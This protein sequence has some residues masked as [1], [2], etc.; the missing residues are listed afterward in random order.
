MEP[1]R[2]E[3]DCG[4]QP[5][6]AGVLWVWVGAGLEST[7]TDTATCNAF[8]WCCT[9]AQV[10]RSIPVLPGPPEQPAAAAAAAAATQAAPPKQRQQQ[11]VMTD[12]VGRRLGVLLGRL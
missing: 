7:H 8:L 11:L 1:A 2:G 5:R 3:H 9:L 6:V 10:H 4:R 12:Q